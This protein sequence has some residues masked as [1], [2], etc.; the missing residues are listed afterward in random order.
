MALFKQSL[1]EASSNERS[2]RVFLLSHSVAQP[3]MHITRR[4]QELFVDG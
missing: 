4:K 2:S 3:V 1:L